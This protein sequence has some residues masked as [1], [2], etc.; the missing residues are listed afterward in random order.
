MRHL[1]SSIYPAPNCLH[2]HL[3]HSIS[4]WRF[5][6]CVVLVGG[7]QVPPLTTISNFRRGS[8]F[9]PSFLPSLA[10]WY[11]LTPGKQTAPLG[12]QIPVGEEY[13]GRGHKQKPNSLQQHS[14]LKNQAAPELK[15]WLT[16]VL[17]PRRCPTSCHF[18]IFLQPQISC[19]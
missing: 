7:Y 6:W 10:P 11:T 5:K 15:P 2:T 3:P 8:I 16:K 4:P 19:Q 14:R 17:M 12:L 13:K 1:T 18:I 9:L